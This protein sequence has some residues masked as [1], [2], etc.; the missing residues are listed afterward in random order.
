MF[1]EF[2]YIGKMYLYI[3]IV[4][5]WF[6]FLNKLNRLWFYCYFFEKDKKNNFEEK[7]NIF[8]KLKKEKKKT[9]KINRF[10]L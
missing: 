9:S 2:E 1:F 10:F 8:K 4:M 3:F 6:I 5:L 7:K